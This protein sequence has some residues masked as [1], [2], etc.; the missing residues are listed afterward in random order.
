[1][2]KCQHLLLI[3]LCAIDLPL[4]LEVEHHEENLQIGE[5][6]IITTI[7]TFI[8]NIVTYKIKE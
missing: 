6:Y 2:T 3:D 1:M 7:T 8:S 4:L 5:K